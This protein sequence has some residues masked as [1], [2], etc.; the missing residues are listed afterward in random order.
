MNNDKLICIRDE[1][2]T[3]LT[4]LLSDGWRIIQISASGIYCWVLLRKPN[5]TKKKRKLKAFSDGE[6]YFNYSG[7]YYDNNTR[8]RLHIF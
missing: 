8:F 1:D 2:D 5:N 3:K 6:I 4:T 7:C